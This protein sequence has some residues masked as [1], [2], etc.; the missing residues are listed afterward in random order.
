MDQ[1]F[2]ILLFLIVIGIAW[3][4]IKAIFKLTM[5]VFSCGLFAIL[6]LGALLFV[7]TN[8]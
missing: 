1:V 3:G 5:K 8:R 2:S 6:A 4:L 7:L